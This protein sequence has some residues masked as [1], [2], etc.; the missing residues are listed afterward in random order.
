MGHNITPA[1]LQGG[2]SGSNTLWK[3]QAFFQ[4][5]LE[6]SHG[7]FFLEWHSQLFTELESCSRFWDSF[8]A[9]FLYLPFVKVFKR[10]STKRHWIS[11]VILWFSEESL[12][13]TAKFKAIIRRGMVQNAGARAGLHLTGLPWQF[14][15]C[16]ENT[17]CTSFTIK[18]SS[19]IWPKLAVFPSVTHIVWTTFDSQ[20]RGKIWAT[21]VRLLYSTHYVILET[22]D[23]IWT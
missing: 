16:H 7:S 6:K 4:M 19:W 14:H 18:N 11:M 9:G 23:C 15:S 21:S 1:H 13:I 3:L 5:L 8:G 2:A 22:I 10:F 20:T 17:R 12:F